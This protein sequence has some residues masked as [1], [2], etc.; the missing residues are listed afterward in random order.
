MSKP[1]HYGRIVL[2]CIVALLYS[3]A[4]APAARAP[5]PVVS[6]DPYAGALLIDTDSGRV[7]FEHNADARLFPAS[8]TKLMTFL[9][10]IEAIE[11]HQITLK[12]T[13][14]ACAEAEAMGGS[15]VH[16]RRGEKFSVE[17]MLYALMLQSANDVAF[18]LAK[19]VG[20]SRQAFIE[21]MNRRARELGM[22]GTEFHSM[23]GL[24]PSLGQKPDFTTA[25]DIA[26]LCRELLRHDATLRYTS[27]TT[28]PFRTN[29]YIMRNHNP[30]LKSVPGCDG[31]KTGYYRAAG[32]SI[33]ATAEQNG[34]RVLAIVLGS[35]NRLVRDAEAKKLLLKGLAEP[36]KSGMQ[37][38]KS[39]VP[40]G[41][42][43]DPTSTSAT[44]F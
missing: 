21:R 8:L 18:A 16:L 20:G 31:L 42:W 33:A 6:K 1:A 37:S 35:R 30:L 43:K 5:I 24:P 7:L 34:S 9:V 14:T 10:V 17:E 2:F 38:V 4:Q 23:H 40:P 19:H 27:A 32:F 12:D 13:V 15:Q 11:N 36:K 25:R 41:A 29:S 39:P 22:T 28:H 44:G 26:R 3:A